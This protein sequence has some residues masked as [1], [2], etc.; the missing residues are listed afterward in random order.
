MRS[1][2]LAFR[3][4]LGLLLSLAAATSNASDGDL[5]PAFGANG[6]AHTGLTNTQA[7]A[8]AIRPDGRVIVC[9]FYTDQTEP[10]WVEEF[11]VAQ[12]LPDGSLDSAFGND[13]IAYVDFS[14]YEDTCTSLTIQ[15]DGRIVAAGYT[16]IPQFPSG[17]SYRP[18]LARLEPNGTLDSSFGAGGLV[19]SAYGGDT[20]AIALQ[21]DGKIILVGFAYEDDGTG[22]DYGVLRLLSDGSP[23]PDF[24]IDGRITFNTD[25]GYT[26]DLAAGVAVDSRQRIVVAGSLDRYFTADLGVLRLL[27][28]GSFDDTFG[29]DGLAVIDS[30]D[31]ASLSSRALR[32]ARDGKILVAGDRTVNSQTD[33]MVARLLDDGS[34]DAT[35]GAQGIATVAFAPQGVA[36]QSGAR[37]LDEQSDGKVVLAGWVR[38]PD[39]NGVLAVAR[40]DANGNADP[41]FGDAGFSTFDL[42]ETPDADHTLDAIALSGG[43]I[44]AAGT[45][46]TD[47]LI[48]LQNDLIFADSF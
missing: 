11:F 17:D 1:F 34:L 38:E 25:G 45:A 47:L 28:D 12:Y 44:L 3:S 29:N 39:N 13:G 26:Y 8:T 16:A 33:M 9:G 42:A 14:A 40:I 35:F 19:T 31:L 24:G 23:D 41:T 46:A 6:V 21:A 32:L 20:A 27:P 37:G 15:P 36:W 48:R 43:R 2:D 10:L 30:G 18:V 22:T 4:G 5:D 7:Y